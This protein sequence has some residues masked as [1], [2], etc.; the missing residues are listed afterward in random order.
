MALDARTYWS[1]VCDR[2]GEDAFKDGEFTA[3]SDREGALADLGDDWLV[4]DGLHYCVGCTVWDDD[5]DELVAKSWPKY[6]TIS[7]PKV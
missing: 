3:Y 5:K 6:P 1:V 7:T 4:F 2:C